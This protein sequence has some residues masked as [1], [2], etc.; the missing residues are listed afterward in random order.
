MPLTEEQKDIV[1]SIGKPMLVLAGPGT[2]KTEVLA[3]KILHLLKGNLASKEE[4]IGIADSKLSYHLS[5]LKE[6]GL[7]NG[8]RKGNWI[9][10]YPTDLGKEIPKFLQG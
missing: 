7:I 6:C 5:T 2:G 3:Y 8:E 10:Y 4:I 9:I 1:E